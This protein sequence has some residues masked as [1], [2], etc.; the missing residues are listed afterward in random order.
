MKLGIVGLPQS[1][2]T[3]IFTALTGKPPGADA[4][5]GRSV[6]E[7]IRVPDKRLERL[8]EV[9]KP[10]S[11]KPATFEATDFGA[12][13]SREARLAA[14][15]ES[16]AMLV[17]LNAFSADPKKQLGDLEA[18]WLLSDLAQVEKRVEKL[19]VL[20]KKPT[21]KE[22]KER[23][24]L[25]LSILERALGG[26][27]KETPLRTMPFEPK[28]R[29]AIKHFGLFTLKPMLLIENY[30]ET[31]LGSYKPKVEGSFAVA[32]KLEAELACM[33]AAER[34]GFLADYGIAEP[35]RERLLHA[36]YR[37][38]GLHAF[39][40]SGEDEVRAWTIPVGSKAPQAAGAIH[41]DFER[42]FIRAEVVHF[43]DFEASG[44]TMKGAKAKNLVRLEGK[45]Y[46]VRDGDMIE[47]RFSV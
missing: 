42:G 14:E 7:I 40:T 44:S 19:R 39:F 13:V 25:E 15:R 34:A 20:V 11:F 17:V 35:A 29:A 12:G 26:L 18:D 6:T 47:F 21:P 3:S 46:V 16:D 32:G 30:P 1:G 28:E 2:K 4:A 36:A 8:R 43:D 27:Q 24:V 45:D 5:A 10:K 22:E 31:Q 23:D 38:L 41:T 33:D 9:F 37:L